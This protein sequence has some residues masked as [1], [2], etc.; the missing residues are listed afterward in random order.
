L[1]KKSIERLRRNIVSFVRKGASQRE[2][3]LHFHVA[4]GTVQLWCRRAQGRRLERVDFSDQPAGNPAPGRTDPELELLILD[5]R[6]YLK[7]QS[8]HGEFG[9]ASIQRELLTL[10][11]GSPPALRTINRI[12]ERHGAIDRRRRIRYPAPP[13]G[14]YLPAVAAR[15]AELD[16]F[17]VVESLAI[18]NGPVVDVLNGI[19]LHGGLP[20]SWPNDR[21][22][23]VFIAEKCVPHW[24]RWGLPA[25]AQ[26]DNDPRFS[27]PP[28]HPGIIGRIPRLCLSLGI[29]PVFA[30]PREPGF[31]N[32]VES[33]NGRW[34]AKVWQRFHYASLPQLRH[35]AE[36]FVSDLIR[37]SALRREQA[38][39]RAA[40]PRNWALDL[41]APPS[42]S[43]IF[44]RRT[45]PH[46][47]V[48]LLGQHFHVSRHWLHRLVRAEVHIHQNRICFHSLR[49]REPEEQRLLNETR[50]TP[51]LVS[52]FT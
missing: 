23:A 17:D 14:W 40:F 36:D 50:Y 20:A 22:N 32:C 4:L 34:V 52:A 10:G 21:V 5:L 29:T 8:A 39:A 42:G 11:F 16:S 28:N 15:R 49:R 24:R 46:G 45:D 25:F 47:S 30:P 12:V 6:N 48:F 9:A 3:A 2:A 35:Q 7:D 44:I 13:R 19:S 43:L 31:Q 51:K 37:F 33:F 38:P 41:H 18:Q 27:G 1:N 26:F